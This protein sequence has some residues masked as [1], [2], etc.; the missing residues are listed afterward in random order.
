MGQKEILR[1]CI[2]LTQ[3]FRDTSLKTKGTLQEFWDLCTKWNSKYSS[4]VQHSEAGIYRI[5]KAKSYSLDK[6]IFIVLAMKCSSRNAQ[7]DMI[8]YP[9]PKSKDSQFL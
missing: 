7:G 1:N 6:L 5:Q 3:T 2:L 8:G 4:P 9:R